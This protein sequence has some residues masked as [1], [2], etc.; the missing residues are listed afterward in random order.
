M[1]L[2]G[3]LR[4]A[5]DEQVV[6]DVIQMH[7]KRRVQPQQLFGQDGGLASRDCLQLLCSPLP[8]AFSH[9]VW[10]AELLR[11]AV[12]AYRAVS[13]DEPVLLVGNTGLAS[14]MDTCAY[15]VSWALHAML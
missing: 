13:F 8:E 4:E 7:F 14:I 6:L 10:T 5:A 12:L 9:L 1:L 2:A 15:I 3:R 11:M